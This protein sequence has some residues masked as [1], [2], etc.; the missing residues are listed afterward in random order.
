MG[1][2]VDAMDS[3]SRQ[4]MRDTFSGTSGE[5]VTM[6]EEVLRRWW[7]LYWTHSVESLLTLRDSTFDTQ[8]WNACRVPRVWAWLEE[9]R[10][11]VWFSD[12]LPVNFS[13]FLTVLGSPCSNISGI[14]CVHVE[15]ILS[16]L[17]CYIAQATER[18]LMTMCKLYTKQT[19][20]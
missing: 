4:D 3:R 15:S 9:T 6:A 11:R 18:N 13:S 12:W 2:T 1:S 19:E 10:D 14:W 7:R 17:Y 20:L 16:A 8:C 5:M